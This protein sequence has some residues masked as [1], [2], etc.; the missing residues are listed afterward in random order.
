MGRP[1][2]ARGVESLRNSLAGEV[3]RPK[4]GQRLKSCYSIPQKRFFLLFN[5]ER[6]IARQ[7]IALL[8]HFA[9]PFPQAG[10]GPRKFTASDTK[11]AMTALLGCG[12]KQ[13]GWFRQGAL[14]AQCRPVDDS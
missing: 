1:D 7:S 10:T 4:Q 5:V 9:A 13:D 11:R 12:R 3:L 2:R 8:L 6:P 14:H